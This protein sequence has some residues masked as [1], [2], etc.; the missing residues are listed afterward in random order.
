MAEG[1][2]INQEMGT[3]NQEGMTPPMEIPPAEGG[4]PAQG[5]VAPTGMEG[6]QSQLPQAQGAGYDLTIIAQRVVGWLNQ[7]PDHEKQHELVKIQLNNPHL[8]SIVLPMLQQSAGAEQSSAAMPLPEQ[9][10][11]QRGPEA[12]TI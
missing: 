7:L 5:A 11:P 12:A 6:V 10:A 1:Q 9:R 4:A 3:M 2:M 8:Y